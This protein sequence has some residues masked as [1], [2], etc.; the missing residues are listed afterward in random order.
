MQQLNASF[1]VYLVKQSVSQSGLCA[2]FIRI[3]WGLIKCRSR[4]SLPGVG[5][6]RGTSKRLS[7][8]AQTLADG[9]LGK[10]SGA[11][12][13]LPRQTDGETGP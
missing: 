8:D 2:T 12:A 6:G 11:A 7:G 3:T 10:S 1:D 13:L 5:A 9:A 4:V